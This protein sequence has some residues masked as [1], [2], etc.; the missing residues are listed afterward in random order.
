MAEQIA[1][2]V[3][4]YTKVQSDALYSVLAHTHTFASLTSKPTTL[5]GYGIAD[6]APLVHTHAAAN[7]TSGTIATARLGTGTADNTTYLRGDNT[8]QVISASDATKLPLAGGT[9]SGNISFA[10]ANQ[11]IWNSDSGISRNAAGILEFN[12]GTTGA[13]RD[14]KF[15][16]LTTAQVVGFTGTGTVTN[17]AGSQT[18]TGTGTLFLSELR[19]GDTVTIGGQSVS[20]LAVNSDVEIFTAAITNANT[21]VAFTSSGG[22]RISIQPNGSIQAPLTPHGSLAGPLPLGYAFSGA[23]STGFIGAV[24]AGG[25]LI[26]T[27]CGGVLVLTTANTAINIKSN[28]TFGWSSGTLTTNNYS[29]DTGFSRNTAGVLEV[30]NGTAGTFRDLLARSIDLRVVSGQAAIIQATTLTNNVYAVFKNNQELWIGV[31]SSG[32]AGLMAGGVAYAG[33]INMRTGYPVQIGSGNACVATFDGS[34]IVT[35]SNYPLSVGGAAGQKV[36]M[37]QQTEFTTIAA[38]AFTDTVITMP[39]FA[40]VV[41]VSVRVT[42]AIPTAATFT[43]GDSGVADRF[44]T[45]TNVAVA[46]GTTNKGTKAGA[47]YNSSALSIRI[48]PNL[49]PATATGVVR[50]T[51]HYIEITPPIS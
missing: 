35:S 50:I 51:I 21:G 37:K 29:A 27:V 4:V 43:V 31:E 7:I 44:N 6:A 46:L 40:I 28:T 10:S 18:V 22:T 41:G 49:T 42:T 33:I 9:M 20:V 19:V 2:Q 13:W 23:T 14:I 38:S 34:G 11:L 30:N 8:W 12:N 39:A 36:S 3:D 15:R 26:G 17:G 5:A 25:G 45:G 16:G 1:K 32:G 48:T 24:P 47:Y